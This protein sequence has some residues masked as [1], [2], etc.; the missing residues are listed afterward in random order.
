MARK[1]TLLLFLFTSVFLKSYAT[2]FVVTN[3]ADAGP[4]TLR[5]AL[6][7]AAANGNTVKDFI[8]F[9]L[10]DVSEAGRTI[11][12]LTAL[13]DLSSNLVVDGSSQ[14]G[15]KIGVSSA[16]IIIKTFRSTVALTVLKASNI[17]HLDIYGF[18]F[19][20]TTNLCNSDPD[21]AE[22][23]AIALNNCTYIQFGAPGKG[24]IINGYK[25]N[26]L[27]FD[28]V[29][30]VIFEDNI[31][32]QSPYVYETICT[33]SVSL[34]NAT[35][36]DIG[37]ADAGNT[38]FA[39][40]NINVVNSGE[41]TD[42][43]NV[44]NNNFGVASDGVT[45]V[46]SAD[47]TYFS[48]LKSIAKETDPYGKVL[49]TISD[50]LIS[51]FG[52][53]GGM[54]FTQLS[55]DIIIKHNWFGTDR[56]ATL[57]LNLQRA[58]PGDSYALY[59]DRIN[60]DVM[61]GDDDP[62]LG[63]KFAYSAQGVFARDMKN[64]LLKR[65]SFKCISNKEYLTTA[66]TLPQ[67]EITANTGAYITGTTE[68]NALV[69]VF[70]SDDC[71]NCSPENYIGSTTADASGN[72]KYTFTKTYTRSIIAN[73]HVG[74]QSSNFT[75]PEINV[76]KLKITNSDCGNSGKVTGVT[77]KNTDK[78][79]WVDD[80]G[81]IVSTELELKGVLPGRYKLIVGEYCTVESD[82]VTIQNSS[83][84]IFDNFLQITSPSCGGNDGSIKR[85]FAYTDDNKVLTYTWFD[86]NS[87]QVGNT[88]DLINVGP[89]M[90]TLKVRSPTGCE[91]SYGPVILNL[92]QGPNVSQTNA[93]IK[94]TLC[95]QATGSITNITAIGTG[96]L[97][98]SWKNELQQE[99]AITK[100]LINMPTGKYI[101]YVTDDV[102]C[103]AIFTSPI[104]I[105]E[106]NGITI[107][108]TNAQ[109]T[110]ASCG[111]NNGS[112]TGI[113]V[114]GGTTFVWKDA[115]NSIVA[116]TLNLTNMPLGDYTLTVSNAFGC[117]KKSAVYHIDQQSPF[118]FPVYA[119]T[120]INS[121]NGVANGTI[122]VN[123][124]AF[125]R[126]YRWVNSI[127]A[128]IG[129]N[130]QL[131]NV[132]GGSYKL[133]LTDNNGCETLYNTY[134]VTEYPEFTVTIYGQTVN[135]HCGLS[136]GSI[137]G[138]TVSG[139]LPP[140]TYKWRD[141]NNQQIAITNNFTNVRADKYILN[142]T[143]AGCGSVDIEYNIIDEEE[144]I[145]PPS[146]NDVTLCSSGIATIA[147]SNAAPTT[148]YRLYASATDIQ[149]VDE[150]TGGKFNV[151][152]TDNRNYYISQMSGTCE[153]PRAEIMVNIG[154]SSSD[155]ANTFTPNN[156]GINDYWKIKNIEN[157]PNALIQVFNR[158]GQLLY[159]S[160]G[161]ASPFNGT[162][163]A[164]QLP[165]GTYFYIINLSSNCSL[166]SG[167][168]TIIR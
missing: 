70:S 27:K 7:L 165:T 162:Y 87:V 1:L 125:A 36:I 57:P 114:T 20:D 102:S 168:L 127:G 6:T 90:Y 154:L 61:I 104:Y 46:H 78:L 75:K 30:N 91:T 161:Y 12:V 25:Y 59:F 58:H 107:N 106:T 56:T 159:Q 109:K 31:F 22:K 37:T 167:S 103:G 150:V 99:V 139:G 73:A 123:I 133:Y 120:V 126:S 146:V 60:A 26:S 79:K 83:P 67:I 77:I 10:P 68:A 82:Y 42:I 149:P 94:P 35:N 76:S 158:A 23:T 39:L 65:N 11:T 110:I 51:H 95:G 132:G 96:T 85:I 17:D 121:C 115:N 142:I 112:V 69:D 160:K 2:N 100:D 101:L 18:F 74:K 71:T 124:D 32:G 44:K 152:V 155:I 3:N 163:N 50:N 4:G 156:D 64:V 33:G 21:G 157:Y 52:Q 141:S 62:S 134:L 63:N 16:K 89:G 164:K 128:T 5:E 118:T 80:K 34:T 137:K 48:I 105:S 135:A 84:Q 24:N 144:I 81:N 131:T 38:F 98:Y 41:V 129:T 92:S 140:Y 8:S 138:T 15:S 43:I 14:P 29:S 143:D 166:L 86:I 40:I 116:T 47:G 151:T 9:N 122:T 19:L 49:L 72:W 147:V 66:T 119:Y 148:T 130:A 53:F 45:T 113:T 117:T 136:N 153:S 13:P 88:S 108:E 54:A 28:G 111:Q 55:G 145:A 93:I 97:K